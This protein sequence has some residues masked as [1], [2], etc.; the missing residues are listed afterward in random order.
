MY[1]LSREIEQFHQ[2]M[3]ICCYT[4]SLMTFFSIFWTI[5]SLKNYQPSKYKTL[6]QT[7]NIYNY[8]KDVKV[9]I[10][11]NYDL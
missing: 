1:I 7:L 6:S 9:L 8:V 11:G 4:F 5:F 10:K 2:M 3:F